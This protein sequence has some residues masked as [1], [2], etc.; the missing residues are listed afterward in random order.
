MKYLPEA[1]F[2][3][4]NSLDHDAPIASAARELLNEVEEYSNHSL[5]REQL[6]IAALRQAAEWVRAT[7]SDDALAWLVMLSR[8]V[9]Q[10]VHERGMWWPVG[11]ESSNRADTLRYPAEGERER[12]DSK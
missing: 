4:R 7:E 3:F 6:A 12:G 8:C 2:D 5:D 11:G 10:Y 9:E 1:C